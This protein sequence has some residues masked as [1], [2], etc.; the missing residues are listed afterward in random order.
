MRPINRLT[1]KERTTKGGMAVRREKTENEKC[2]DLLVVAIK[3]HLYLTDTSVP[4]LADALRICP[5]TAYSRI[6][7]PGT[8]TLDELRALKKKLQIP[9][10]ELAGLF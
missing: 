5:A 3:K 8:F 10:D 9:N 6:R 1:T 4:Q 7:N 2:N